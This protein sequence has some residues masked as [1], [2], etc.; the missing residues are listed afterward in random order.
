MSISSAILAARSGLNVIG[1]RADITATNIANA[2]TPGYVRRALTVSET[3]LGTET[4]GVQITSVD[5]SENAR[6]T[7]ERRQLSSD[8]AQADMLSTTW[9]SLS[10]RI[11]DDIDSSTLF[12]RLTNMEAALEDARLSPESTTHANQVVQ[13]ANDLVAE[14]NSLSTLISQE[15]QRAD[16]NIAASV[17]VIN[18]SLLEIENLNRSLASID[19]TTSQ[20]AALF[21]ERDRV[22]DRISEFMPVQAVPRD[23]G[24][25]DIITPEGV[26]LVAGPAKQISFTPMNAVGPSQ[27]LANGGLSG[28]MVDDLDITPGGVTFGAVSSGSIAALFTL[29]DSDLT[30]LE[31]QLDTMAQDLIDRFSDPSIDPTNPLG[32]PGLF[33]DIDATAGAGVAGRLELNALVDPARGGAVWRLRDGLG[34]ATPGDPGNNTILTNLSSALTNVRSVS[35]PGLQGGFTAG[36]L[37]AQLGSLAGQQRIQNEAVRSSISL[38]FD[39][40]KQSEAN[41]TAVDIE[42][43]MQDLLIIEQAFA[44]NARV[45]QVASQML[46]ELMEI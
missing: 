10:Q 12:Q 42:R 25:V 41:E 7:A 19:R 14:F 17:E 34:A 22:I 21:D 44:A 27:T 20:A 5:R 3:I 13:S 28:L 35:V 16:Q 36:D 43:E 40:V 37:V 2:S 24:A 6:L 46:T 30:T 31:T 11:G 38:Q 26:F 9:A 32:D 29:R 4:A 39:T 8:F 23:S 1:A 33:L 45:I 18:E 15:R